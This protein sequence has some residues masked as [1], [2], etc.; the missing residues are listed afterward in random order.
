MLGFPIH[1]ASGLRLLSFQLFGLDCKGLPGTTRPAFLW[2]SVPINSK[3][4]FLI[5]NYH[6][7]GHGSSSEG[8]GGYGLSV[9]GLRL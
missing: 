3:G 4:G 9:K 2:D 1:Y 6:K 5:R 7:V 8:C